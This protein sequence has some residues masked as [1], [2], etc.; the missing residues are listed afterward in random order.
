MFKEMDPELALK[1]I[2]GYENELAPAT[3]AQD[4]FY[5]QHSCPRCKGETQKHF[6][7]IQHAFGDSSSVI[8]RS[9]LKCM[10]CECVFDPH[11]GVVVELGKGGT[12]KQKV[13]ESRED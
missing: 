5:R 4:A 1:L 6:L 3:K 9:G 10:S 7:N 2:E 11:S 12:V 8:P 13:A